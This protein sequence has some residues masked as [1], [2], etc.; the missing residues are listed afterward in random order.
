M[1]PSLLQTLSNFVQFSSVDC[2]FRLM[3]TKEFEFKSSS[4]QQVAVYAGYLLDAI[5]DPCFKDLKKN[6]Y[7]LSLMRVQS[8]TP[9]SKY[10]LFIEFEPQ[11]WMNT[12][13]RKL[14]SRSQDDKKIF[15][16]AVQDF[17]ESLN[18][19]VSSYRDIW[20]EFSCDEID[21][22]PVLYVA[23]RMCTYTSCSQQGH[24]HS[25]SYDKGKTPRYPT[26]KVSGNS[27]QNEWNP[28]KNVY[29]K[30][31]VMDGRQQEC[32]FRFHPNAMLT[33]GHLKGV[34]E[35]YEKYKSVVL[36]RVEPVLELIILP[37]ISDDGYVMLKE[38]GKRAHENKDVCRSREFWTMVF[39]F[40][41]L[42]KGSANNFFDEPL[43][44]SMNFGKW[45]SVTSKSGYRCHAHLH[46]YPPPSISNQSY[47]FLKGLYR[48]PEYYAEKNMNLLYSSLAYFIS[49]DFLYHGFEDM[50]R[51]IVNIRS[52]VASLL[53]TVNA[54]GVAIQTMQVSI[55]TMQASIQGMQG[56]IQTMQGS[57]QSI[58]TAMSATA[59]T[60]P[61]ASQQ[62]VPS[63]EPL[64]LQAS[65]STSRKQSLTKKIKKRISTNIFSK[66][67]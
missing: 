48:Q 64:S 12:I 65:S 61:E 52:D 41:N 66:N 7:R 53:P 1:D 33:D 21:E 22:K 63:L 62:N 46:L 13:F 58:Q 54:M 19:E 40:A 59:T 4:F 31:L 43:L 50:Q 17:L 27:L 49:N 37:A 60:G 3:S 34:E 2:G 67:K 28:S 9:P 5:A 24:M 39:E 35:L 11:T 32:G 56:S 25:W 6:G 23:P 38:S 30:E 8:N 20:N 57:I 18:D 36:V 51:D 15:I 55:Q 10:K 42:L 45:E 47:S 29:C 44:F 26:T 14:R 16:R